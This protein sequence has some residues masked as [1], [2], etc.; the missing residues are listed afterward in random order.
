MEEKL[1]KKK[2]NEKA[3]PAAKVV[4]P[5]SKFI[6][7]KTL[8]RQSDKQF[9]YEKQSKN[10]YEFINKKTHRIDITPAMP[11]ISS[12]LEEV[13]EIRNRINDALLIQEQNKFVKARMPANF[14]SD[15]EHV[16][17]IVKPSIRPVH[18]AF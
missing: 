16:K 8:M 6:Q 11:Y 2:K 18:E 15:F 13:L 4:D 12:S 14:N 3:K 1:G 10:P 9:I 5:N 17:D 7:F